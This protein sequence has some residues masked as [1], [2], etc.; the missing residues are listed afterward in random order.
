MPLLSNRRQAQVLDALQ[1]YVTA[2]RGDAA[3]ILIRATPSATNWCPY[4][5][6][7]WVS[8]RLLTLGV[9]ACRPAVTL[10]VGRSLI[11]RFHLFKPLSDERGLHDLTCRAFETRRVEAWLKR[12]SLGV[13]VTLDR[14]EEPMRDISELSPHFHTFCLALM[15]PRRVYAFLLDRVTT[16]TFREQMPALKTYLY[17]LPP[18]RSL[19]LKTNPSDRTSIARHDH[20]PPSHD[21]IVQWQKYTLRDREGGG[22]WSTPAW[23]DPLIPMS[24]SLR[25]NA[26]GIE[27]TSTGRAE[28]ASRYDVEVVPLLSATYL[29]A[30]TPETLSF[31]EQ[32]TQLAAARAYRVLETSLPALNAL[33][34]K[35]L[36]KLQGF[37]LQRTRHE[38]ATHFEVTQ[39]VSARLMMHA[40][41]SEENHRDLT[42]KVTRLGRAAMS[43]LAVQAECFDE[44][45]MM[46]P[47]VPISPDRK[48]IPTHKLKPYRLR[49]CGLIHP[50]WSRYE[51]VMHRA[52]DLHFQWRGSNRSSRAR[53]T[54]T[55]A[56]KII[57][58]NINRAPRES[59]HRS[60]L[61]RA[62][63]ALDRALHIF[64]LRV[65]HAR[66]RRRVRAGS[67]ERA[68]VLVLNVDLT[69][70][71]LTA[72]YQLI[73]LALWIARR[74]SAAQHR[75]IMVM[76][77]LRGH[78]S[79]KQLTFDPHSDQLSRTGHA[80]PRW[81]SL[82]EALK[83]W[84]TSPL[85]TPPPA[86]FASPTLNRAGTSPER[87]PHTPRG[88]AVFRVL[89]HMRRQRMRAEANGELTGAP[90][91]ISLRC[92]QERGLTDPMI[93]KVKE[94]RLMRSLVAFT[95]R[96]TRSTAPVRL[97]REAV[98]SSEG[99]VSH[100]SI[101]ARDH[102]DLPAPHLL[103]ASIHR[104]RCSALSLLDEEALIRWALETYKL[105]IAL[106][107]SG[108]SPKR[109]SR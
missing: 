101:S 9:E 18:R 51:E 61:S 98:I 20:L 75:V 68:P 85:G 27:L 79:E 74:L 95:Q 87:L 49:F 57:E 108:G 84:A 31:R 97:M 67:T 44:L 71:R 91:V 2:L 76:S 6:V 32:A 37:N 82:S 48:K 15:N 100:S 58:R 94:S 73:D 10:E 50:V 66:L 72:A 13:G 63:S 59:A 93:S 40:R 69:G 14:R 41:F 26:Q 65:V 88:S 25:W 99:L 17:H 103:S 29:G 43:D 62:F 64:H 22:G 80:H 33:Y 106:H 102:S 77:H 34:L 70:A 36:R 24:L 19:P 16:L 107:E 11:S 1:L 4:T 5:Q 86:L 105:I 83:I 35:D 12:E 90:V 7:L 81:A 8:E 56:S 89:G 46:C 96:S 30:I 52:R 28:L 3:P 92:A 53:S 45:A 47:V 21:L 60:D 54:S 104:P 55:S 42:V 78:T 23:V 109:V 38:V 39:G